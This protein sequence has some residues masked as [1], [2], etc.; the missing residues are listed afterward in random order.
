[1]MKFLKPALAVFVAG[2]LLAGCSSSS[3]Q[4]KLDPFAGKGS[5]Y[6]SGKGPIPWGGGRSQ[7]GKP[8]QVAG[9]WFEP[10]EQPGYDKTGKASWYGE[11]FHKRKTSNGE[12]FDMNRLTAA[13]ATLPLPSYARVTN[14]DNGRT[15]VVR[16][17]D[18]GP[19]VGT[20]VIDLSKKSADVLGYKNQGTAHV[21][22]Q[23]IGPAPLDD[24]GSHLLAMNK[25]NVRGTPVRSMIASADRHR[26]RSTVS[27]TM[28]AEAV[29][30]KK[31]AKPQRVAVPQVE[32]VAYQP[33]QE[34]EVQS[35][36]AS[37]YETSYFVQLGSFTDPGNAARARDQFASVWP[38]QFIELMGANGP[39][40]RV[41]LGPIAEQADA[42]T[43]LDNAYAAGFN[44]ARMIRSQ[45]MQASL[46]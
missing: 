45:A 18:R 17:N 34:P 10:R 43:A 3:K 25:E 33:P 7:V 30:P 31:P 2:L 9:R 24:N 26:S 27:D 44:D 29:A 23:Y 15:V 40:Y 1:M 11:A 39:V 4:S 38:V 6:Y 37:G 35:Q 36:Q 28:V 5:P 19:F 22:V 42:M 32:T 20:R 12:W 13:H 8:Y 46:Q 21:R 41:R 14:L 16:I